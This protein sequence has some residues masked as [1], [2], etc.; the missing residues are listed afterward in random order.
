MVSLVWGKRDLKT[1]FDTVFA[2]TN[3][4]W[5]GKQHTKAIEGNDCAIRHRIGL[6]YINVCHWRKRQKSRI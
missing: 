2:D 1:A 6:A 5:V 3:E 4:R